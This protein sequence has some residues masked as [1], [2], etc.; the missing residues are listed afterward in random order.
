MARRPLILVV[1]DEHDFRAIVT[2]VLERGGYDVV[3]APNG[4]DGIKMFSDYGPALV[5]LDGNLPDMDGIDVCRRIRQTEKGKTVP[6]VMCT[7]RSAVGTVGEGL[8]AGVTDY[9]VK[10]FE[11][12][13]L[14][15]RVAKALERAAGK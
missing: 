9:V 13:E 5:V 3:S 8:S 10:P 7:V 6:V 15:E 2:H 11:M 12:E 4:E 1:D 14:L